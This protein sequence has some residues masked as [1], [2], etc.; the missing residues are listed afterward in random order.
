MH[1][2]SF[3]TACKLKGLPKEWASGCEIFEGKARYEVKV[4][5]VSKS[6]KKVL[7]TTY[8]HMYREPLKG[9]G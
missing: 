5:V 1:N 7:A 6:R 9:F 8:K 3:L 4:E 2:S